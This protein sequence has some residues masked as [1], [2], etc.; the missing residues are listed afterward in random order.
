MDKI[1]EATGKTEEK[2]DGETD[3]ELKPAS[4]QDSCTNNLSSETLEGGSETV[5]DS[6]KKD[7]DIKENLLEDSKAVGNDQAD[8]NAEKEK[9]VTGGESTDETPQPSEESVGTSEMEGEQ[10]KSSNVK[11]TGTKPL[12][13]TAKKINEEWRRFNLDLSPKVLKI[14]FYFAAFRNDNSV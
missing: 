14:A 11:D 1:P 4:E 8:E 6:S 10:S 7:E 13:W 9:E 12:K 5:S 3:K 2:M